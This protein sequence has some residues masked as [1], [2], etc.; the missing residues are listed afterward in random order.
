MW[1]PRLKKYSIHKGAELSHR[2]T[3]GGTTSP[4]CFSEFTQRYFG[5]MES[6]Y[7]QA[8]RT[9][10]FHTCR[11]PRR[12]G[13]GEGKAKGDKRQEKI[14]TLK[15]QALQEEQTKLKRLFEVT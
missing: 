4:G 3:G 8:K 14:S 13:R 9:A 15:G 7:T 10:S 5:I 6:S 12:E 2:Q 11:R 1:T